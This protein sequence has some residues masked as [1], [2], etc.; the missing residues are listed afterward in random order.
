ML[1]RFKEW[2]SNHK[3]L[4]ILSVSLFSLLLLFAIFLIIGQRFYGSISGGIKIPDISNIFKEE[5]IPQDEDTSSDQ[6]SLIKNLQLDFLD[7]PML[8][9][10][11]FNLSKPEEDGS[12]MD[13]YIKEVYK[14]ADVLGGT[15]LGDNFKGCEVFI[16]RYPSLFMGARVISCGG[17]KVYLIGGYAEIDGSPIGTAED[18]VTVVFPGENDTWDRL[19]Y[20]PALG[21]FGESQTSKNGNSFE[22]RS[23]RFELYKKSELAEVDKIGQWP[24]YKI[25]SGGK[26]E[27]LVSSPEGFYQ[28]LVLNPGIVSFKGEQKDPEVTIKL[29]NGSTV[30][31]IYDYVSIGGCFDNYIEVAN[32]KM[33]DLTK[34][35]TGINGDNIYQDTDRNTAYLKKVYNEDYAKEDG[36]HKYNSIN[37]DDTTPY[38]YDK[39]SKSYPV[40]YLVDSF[41]RVI[42]FARRDFIATGGCAKPAIYLYS[43]KTINLN[44]KV[45]P[46]GRLTFTFPKYPVSGWDVTASS[47]GIV[48]YKNNSYP[49]LWWESTSYGY[50]IPN[51]GWVVKKENVQDRISE[52][53]F[54]YG[55]NKTEVEDFVEYWLPIMEQENSSYIF[56]TFLV[57]NQVNQIAKLEFSVAPESMLRLFMVY[58]PLDS[59]K[60]VTPLKIEKIQREGF[61][62]IEWGGAK[63]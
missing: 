40:I 12:D 28:V 60:E 37:D 56:F 10:K 59:Y 7:S 34:I 29:N 52:I 26:G 48:E 31:A 41:D 25:I 24:I 45:I 61:T 39:F 9:N 58:K 27:F 30:S 4:A 35:G 53:L 21:K 47:S 54:A 19:F 3:R 2:A 23:L 49:Y 14:T 46:N 55:L 43:D 32:V 5:E 13:T 17:G 33:S 8:V 44:V 50:A 51:N 6:Q 16:L 63:Y 1:K 22:V 36:V 18:N 57:D 20:N 42:K 38:S 15:Y 11:K 62:V